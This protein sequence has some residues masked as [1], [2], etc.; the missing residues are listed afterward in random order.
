MLK[1]LSN[2]TFEFSEPHWDQCVCMCECLLRL[3]ISTEPERIGIVN[4]SIFS[5]RI[6]FYAGCENK[7]FRLLLQWKKFS[8]FL[9][10]YVSI[11]LSLS[12]TPSYC[13][14]SLWLAEENLVIIIFVGIA[15]EYSL[16][17]PSSI[18]N[19]NNCSTFA[20]THTHTHN[21]HIPKFIS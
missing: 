4:D 16:N 9:V 5:M 14:I 21:K 8:S 1:S 6:L 7:N 13:F 2:K 10:L 3:H 17:S 15:W 20:S 12:I 19:Y 11:S 18:N